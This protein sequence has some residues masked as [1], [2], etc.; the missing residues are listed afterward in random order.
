M[1]YFSSLILLI[2]LPFLSFGQN[3]LGVFLGA[4]GYQGDLVKS[5]FSVKGAGITGGVLYKYYLQ[6]N[7]AIR[8]ALNVGQYNGD[9]DFFDS[10]RDRGYSFSSNFIDVSIVAE[11][12][13]FGKGAYTPSGA[14]ERV[15]SP[16]FYVGIGYM[17]SNPEVSANGRFDVNPEDENPQK[18]HRMF[19]AGAGL[20]YDLSSRLNIAGEF[21]ARYP[22]SDLIDGISASGDSSDLDWYWT[23]GITLNYKLSENQPLR[24][25]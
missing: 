7:F 8:G 18:H 15:F 13:I 25:N 23:T 24:M 22:F 5:S 2:S 4:T 11:Y 6:D 21:S 20:K 1:K 16:Y 10:E 12:S 9:D 14:F 17:N 3:E 19:P